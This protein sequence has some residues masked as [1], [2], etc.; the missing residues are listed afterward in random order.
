[1]KGLSDVIG[2]VII[3]ALILIVIIP[4]LLYVTFSYSNSLISQTPPKPSLGVIN[5]TYVAKPG[6]ECLEVEYTPGTPS[7]TVVAI[8]NYSVKGIWV[9]ANYAVISS[10]TNPEKYSIEGPTNTLLVELSYLNQIYYVQV[11]ANASVLVG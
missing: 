7:P 6:N 5:V 4:L 11:G 1:M 2:F 10:S 9:N 8:F 3:L